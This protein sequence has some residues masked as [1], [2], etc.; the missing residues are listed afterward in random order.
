MEW[1]RILGSEGESD[2][3]SVTPS[4]AARGRE[5][6]VSR[7]EFNVRLLDTSLFFAVVP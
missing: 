1:W 2:F 3:L 5:W 7:R 4:C 6:A